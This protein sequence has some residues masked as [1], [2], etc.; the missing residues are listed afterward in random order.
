MNYIEST[1]SPT[2]GTSFTALRRDDLK[3]IDVAKGQIQQAF[4][5]PQ[6]IRRSV[7]YSFLGIERFSGQRHLLI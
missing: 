1:W 6:L 2:A 7:D 3:V 5:I 4:D